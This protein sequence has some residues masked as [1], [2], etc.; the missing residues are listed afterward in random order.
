MYALALLAAS[1]SPATT[2]HTAVA[3]PPRPARRASARLARS[4][5]DP[6]PRALPPATRQV[7]GTTALHI[8]CAHGRAAFTRLLLAAGA[9]PNA[10]D[11]VRHHTVRAPPPLACAVV[12]AG[13]CVAGPTHAFTPS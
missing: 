5:S 13:A 11:N 10:K 9:D 12:R 4:H 1:A 2:P 7:N 8:A 3:R 6:R